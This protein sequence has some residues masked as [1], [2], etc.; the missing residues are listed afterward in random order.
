MSRNPDNIQTIEVPE[1]LTNL[2]PQLKYKFNKPRKT[3]TTVE[4][5]NETAIK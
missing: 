5:L 3:I 2:P 4:T 1:F